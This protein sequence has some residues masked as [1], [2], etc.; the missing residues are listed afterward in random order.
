MPLLPAAACGELAGYGAWCPGPK[1]RPRGSG[2]PVKG[3]G[4]ATREPKDKLDAPAAA[5]VNGPEGEALAWLSTGGGSRGTYGVFGSGSSRR[6]GNSPARARGLLEPGAG[7]TRTPGSEGARPQQCGRATRHGGPDWSWAWI[8]H[9]IAESRACSTSTPADSPDHH[10]LDKPALC[11]GL[12]SLGTCHSRRWPGSAR[13]VGPGPTGAWHQSRRPC[14]VRCNSLIQTGSTG[15]SATGWRCCPTSRPRRWPLT[16]R[17]CAA[18]GTVPAGGCTCS[19]RWPTPA[20]RSSR[21]GRSTASR[22]RSPSSGRCWSGSTWPARSSPQMPCTPNAPTPGT[23]SG[24]ERPTTCWWSRTTSRAWSMRS[25]SSPSG[26][27]PLRTTRWSVVTAVWST[28][29]SARPRSPTRWTS[30]TP[31]RWWSSI[32]TPPTLPGARC[33]PRSLRDHQ[34]R[35]RAGQRRSAG[36]AASG[37]L[38]DR[39]PAALGA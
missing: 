20:A 13:R 35:A 25:I 2:E 39:E 34:P 14:G 27:V 38:G 9:M 29:G 10:Q 15:W 37:P 6:R 22:A 32:G 7:T 28:A 18:P 30:P 26:R 17:P 1:G 5:G 19:P 36:T 11:R 4:A 31:P 33:A 3:H 8:P 21:S 24:T 12:D 16:A 23:W